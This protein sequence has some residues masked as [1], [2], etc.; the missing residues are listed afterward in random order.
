MGQITNQF[1]AMPWEDYDHYW[2]RSPLSM[3]GKVNTPVMLF[4]GENDRRVPMSEIEQFYQAL[5]L[6]KVDTAM[7]RVPDAS[8][9]VTAR[10]SNMIAKIEH[11]LAWFKLYHKK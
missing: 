5:Q 7:V 3:A 11:T 6:R 2:K 1:P 8:H 9:G 10:P 4:S